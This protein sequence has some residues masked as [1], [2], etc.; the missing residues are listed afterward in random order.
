MLFW[1][2]LDLYHKAESYVSHHLTSKHQCKHLGSVP[3]LNSQT[4][5]PNS[6][7]K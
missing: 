1:G 7:E 5:S 3:N 4:S 2:N 6:D